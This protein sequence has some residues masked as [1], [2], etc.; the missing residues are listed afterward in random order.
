LT[1]APGRHLSVSVVV[2]QPELEALRSTVRSLRVAL[3]RARERRALD[4]ASL[5]LIDNGSAEPARLDQLAAEALAPDP[6][7]L[8]LQVLRGHGN[9]GYGRGHNLAIERAAGAYHL[10]INPDVQ[11]D[12]DAVLEA[13]G[14]IETHAAVGMVT[15]H[16]VTESGERQFLCKRFPSVLVLGLRAFAPAWLRA[17]FRGR[18]DRY[19]MRDATRDA[20]F[21][22]IPI[23]SGCFMLSRREPLQAVGG[24]SPEYFL[25][26]EDFDLS[27]RFNQVAD[28]AYVPAVRIVHAGGLAARKGWRHRRMFVRSAVTFFRRHGWRLW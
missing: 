8:R 4:D 20:P 22:P 7:W 25:Y 27:L 19:E 16:A 5:W 17:P 23:A 12:P 11:L 2:Y 6:G 1:A 15:P 21:T 13:L 14:Y 3:D 18:L 28:I 26:F 9:V 24:F 10:V